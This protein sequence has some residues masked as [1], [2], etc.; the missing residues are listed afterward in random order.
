MCDQC[1]PYSR[2]DDKPDPSAAAAEAA[3]AIRTLNHVTLST[4]W[5][6]HPGDVSAVAGALLRLAER[7]P[8]ALQQVYAEL[9]RLDQAGAIR[10]DNGADP[11][12]EAGRVL[13]ALQDARGRAQHLRSVLATAAS[14][15]D[16]MGGHFQNDEDELVDTGDAEEWADKVGIIKTSHGQCLA[17]HKPFDAGD[18]RWDGHN[19]HDNTDWCRAC[20]DRCH[21][22]E[23]AFHRCPVCAETGDGACRPERD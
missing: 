6:D 7:L 17:C 21:E 18:T 12:V 13:V 2:T 1:D 3:E 22:S 20:V 19:R 9:D 16:H 15:L 14:G 10:M 5:A 4:G 11:V 8:Q 23:D